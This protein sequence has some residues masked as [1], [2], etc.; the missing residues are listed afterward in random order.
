MDPALSAAA[1]ALLFGAAKIGIIGTVGF[2]IAWFRARARMQRL[3][4]AAAQQL[5]HGADERVERMEQTMEYV[6]GQLDRIVEAQD[7]LQR[8]LAAPPADRRPKGGEE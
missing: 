6:V 8:Q 1:I 3:E 4:A 2:G 7:A 5:S